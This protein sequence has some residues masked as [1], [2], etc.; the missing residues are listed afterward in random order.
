M[1][2]NKTAKK[3]IC[4]RIIKI[5]KILFGIIAILLVLILVLALIPAR[6][7]QIKD[8]NGKVIE[9][10]IAEIR[11]VTVGGV[12]QYLMIRGN[13]INNPVILFIHG[14]PGQAEIG[15]IRELQKELE[16]KFVVVRWDQRGSGLSASKHIPK[17]S[18]N[19]HTLVSDAN[20]ITDYL[21]KRF[22]KSQIFIAAHS[23]GTIVATNAVKNNPEKYSAYIGIGQYSDS[24]ESEKTSYEYA[25]SEAKR[26]N[27]KEI[28]KQ[29]EKI[30]PPPYTADDVLTRAQCLSQLGCIF[31]TEPQ[32]NM[33]KSLMLSP[34]YNLVTKLYYLK[35]A[36]SSIQMLKPE[37]LKVNFLEEVTE[38]KVPVY[39]IMGKYDYFTPTSIVEKFYNKL[40]A[41]KKELILFENSAHIPQLEENQKFNKTIIRI[42]EENT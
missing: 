26:Q 25:V 14:G 6:T 2:I 32:I 22:N 4:M 28:L 8:K 33:S 36:L 19:A 13:N 16:E 29:L 23:W 10:S 20:E 3:E 9:N 39:F 7:P 31:K 21:I 41:P 1:L 42:L 5:L 38:L 35:N 15:Y 40:Q 34:E 18:I 12:S 17:E 24:K 11:K 27:N 30:G 37:L